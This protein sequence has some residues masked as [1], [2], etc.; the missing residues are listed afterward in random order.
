MAPA[1]DDDV[2]QVDNLGGGVAEAVDA[3]QG[4]VIGAD[5]QLEQTS[6][7]GDRPTCGE[8][9]VAAADRVGDV[10]CAHLLF[11]RS[12]AGDLRESVDGNA[13]G[14]IDHHAKHQPAGVG[15]RSTPLLHRV[16]GKTRVHHVP[17]RVNPGSGRPVE[18][19]DGD[20]SAV[21]EPDAGLLE[22][23]AFGVGCA[24]GSEQNGV[25]R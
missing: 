1:L 13:G 12:C 21:I 17:R 20:P 25:R 22:P 10:G 16:G 2:A 7:A 6:V 5:D 24:A 15:R 9:K 11:G 4:A 14:P 18:A 19:V 8:S 23:E 3:E